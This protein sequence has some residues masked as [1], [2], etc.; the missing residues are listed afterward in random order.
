M[1]LKTSKL[2]NE[3]VPNGRLSNDE[4]LA[5]VNMDKETGDFLKEAYIRLELSMRGYYK[6]LKVART[7]ADL[8][9]SEKVEI[10]HIAE[11]LGYRITVS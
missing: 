11:A 4:I 6:V 7:I 3:N 9:S 10:N 1:K 8:E 5:V 2:M